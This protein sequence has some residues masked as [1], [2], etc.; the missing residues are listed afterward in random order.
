MYQAAVTYGCEEGGEGEI[1]AEDADA[2]IAFVEG[3]GVAGAKKDVV[4]G[5]GIF[6]ESG[7]VIG[8]SVKV[9]EDSARKAALGETAKIL[10]VYYAWWAE[11]VHSE[12]HGKYITEK[13]PAEA[14]RNYRGGAQ[15]EGCRKI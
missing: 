9:V 4:E 11:G 13:H 3:D 7:F 8:T 12:G 14:M 6:S 2:E 10:D 1:E 5:T 15:A